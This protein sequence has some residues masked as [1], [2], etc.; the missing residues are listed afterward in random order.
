ML[1]CSVTSDMAWT[2]QTCFCGAQDRETLFAIS[3]R[4][5]CSSKREANLCRCC[6]CASL[7][8]DVFPSEATIGAAYAQYYTDAEGGLSRFVDPFRRSYMEREAPQEGALVDYGCGSGGYLRSLD[9]PNLALF[10]YDRR[11]PR[12][13]QGFQSI[14]QLEDC[15]YDYITLS[16]VI[17]HVHDPRS[18]LRTLR[19]A[20]RDKGK[21]WLSTPDAGS[22]LIASFGAHARDI[23]FPRHRVIFS[24]QALAQLAHETGFRIAWRKPPLVNT[25]L[26]L[27]TCLRNL[28]TDWRHLRPATGSAPELVAVLS[29][30]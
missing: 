12:D 1:S 10:G 28:G 5:F 26:N 14:D 13:T 16:H 9:R 18:L 6:E 11:T 19:P 17:E 3:D 22:F 7:F 30:A 20:L 29:R 25:L 2:A 8:P 21:I 27:A 23:D 15:R 24:R 4:N